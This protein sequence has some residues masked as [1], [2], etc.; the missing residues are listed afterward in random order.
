LS[1][2]FVR[3]IAGLVFSVTVIGSALLGQY[4]VGV[5][6]LFFALGGLWEFIHLNSLKLKSQPRYAVTLFLGF[7][8]YVLFFLFSIGKVEVSAFWIF[9]PLMVVA[10]CLEI[11]STDQW[12]IQQLASTF[13]GLAYV[14]VPFSFV[15]LLAF[16]SGEFNY[17]LPVGFFLIL[18]ANDTGAYLIGRKIG[19]HKLYERISP[20]KTIEGL[21][22]GVLA[23]VLTGYGCSTIFNSLD[24]SHWLVIALIVAVFANVGDLFESHIK[25][26]CGVKDSGKIIPGHGGVLDRFDGLLM[27]LPVVIV[28]LKLI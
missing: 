25:R 10:S 1:N 18:W 19:R 22:G 5:L 2:L 21:V 12:S 15:S 14:I 7:V 28:Y 13:F 9:I 4:A 24:L 20:N 8:L 26:I 11:F 6:F 16:N 27:A 23:S 3:T 17:E